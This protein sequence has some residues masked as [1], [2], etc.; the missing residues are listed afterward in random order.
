MATKQVRVKVFDANGQL[1]GPIEMPRVEKSD[2]E[3]RR[4]L[5]PEQYD[6]AR[7]K[8]TERPFCGTLLDNKR[9][10]VYACV[11]CNLPLFTSDNKFNSGTGWPSFFQPIATENLRTLRC[12]SWPRLR[13]WTAAYRATLLCEFRIVG[14]YRPRQRELA[15]RPRSRRASWMTGEIAKWR[16]GEIEK[17]LHKFHFAIPISPFQFR[18]SS[19]AILQFRHFAISMSTMTVPALDDVSP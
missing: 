17:A 19:F 13:R 10:G 1:V 4:Q 7:R 3:W 18:H 11:C 14:F 16:N 6:V 12:T 8:G 15:R 5:T 9:D 2:Q